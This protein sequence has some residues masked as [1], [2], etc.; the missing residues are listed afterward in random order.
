MGLKQAMQIPQAAPLAATVEI[1]KARPEHRI[2]IT[3]IG[4]WINHRWPI[5]LPC[6]YNEWKYWNTVKI[7]S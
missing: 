4:V 3:G 7:R 1:L 6:P 5:S 2:D